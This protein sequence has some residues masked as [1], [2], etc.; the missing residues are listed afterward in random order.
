L[1]TYKCWDVDVASGVNDDD[2]TLLLGKEIV[3]DED[4]NFA[5][6]V[7]MCSLSNFMLELRLCAASVINAI[8]RRG[9]NAKRG[10]SRS[11]KEPQQQLSPLQ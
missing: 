2:R 1:E 6:V 8:C 4:F 3:L 7:D 5:R 9:R 10:R 11:V